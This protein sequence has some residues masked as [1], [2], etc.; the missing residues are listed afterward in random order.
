MSTYVDQ[1][2]ETKKQDSLKKLYTNAETLYGTAKTNAVT[3][4][5]RI[6]NFSFL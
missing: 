4:L 2:W 6:E 5:Q 1:Y 3:I